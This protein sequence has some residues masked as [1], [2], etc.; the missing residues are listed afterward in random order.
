MLDENRA[1]YTHDRAAMRDTSWPFTR[2]APEI[3]HISDLAIHFS[4]RQLDVSQ[5]TAV[6]D[7]ELYLAKISID[8]VNHRQRQR[9]EQS[10]KPPD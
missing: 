7:S 9:Q 4:A 8:Q 1:V 10:A 5:M 2:G 6:F 3:S